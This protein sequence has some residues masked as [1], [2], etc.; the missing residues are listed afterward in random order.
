MQG[1]KDYPVQLPEVVIT[2]RGADA[3]TI[4]RINTIHPRLRVELMDIYGEI[5]DALS[6]RATCRFTQV[7]RT[8]KEQNDLY[9][10]G[11]TKPGKKVTNA[12]GGDSYHNYGLAVDFCLIIDRKEVSWD[13][14]KDYDGD[15]KADWMEVVAIFKKYGWE[16]GGDWASLKDYPHF[17]K[18]LGKSIAQLKAMQKDGA[19]YPVFK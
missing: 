14:V 1:T 10:Q 17:Q 7:L 5:L 18:A 9:A 19:G 3:I 6:G 8:I 2:R 11:R 12:K 13:M 4:S 15:K 16:W